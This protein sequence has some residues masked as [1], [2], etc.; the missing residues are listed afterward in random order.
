[1]QNVLTWFL[2]QMLKEPQGHDAYLQPDTEPE[3]HEYKNIKTAAE[4]L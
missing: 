2:Q 4:D 3:L 1:M